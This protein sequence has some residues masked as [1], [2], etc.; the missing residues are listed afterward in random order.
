MAINKIAAP[1]STSP[2]VFATPVVNQLLAL[3]IASEKHA[4][5]VDGY[6]LKGSMFCILGELFVADSNTA[7]SGTETGSVAVRFTVSGNAAVAEYVATNEGVWNGAYF[8]FYDSTNRLYIYDFLYAGDVLN[9]DY[10]ITTSE[11]FFAGD[12]G[13][14]NRLIQASKRIK[15]SGKYRIV[16]SFSVVNGS[17][18]AVIYK[19]GYAYGTVRSLNKT[20][21]TFTEDLLFNEGDTLDIYYSATNHDIVAMV[22]FIEIS[23]RNQIG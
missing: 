16:L 17:V 18:N 4:R 7:I 21:G 23:I 19:N 2:S 11:S 22:Q 13:T 15:K 10:T 6:V 12:I 9:P 14:W 20:S 5:I 1:L 8:G 3:S